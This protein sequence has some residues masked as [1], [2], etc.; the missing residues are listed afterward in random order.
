[1]LRENFDRDFSVW[2]WRCLSSQ[3]HQ[4]V[5]PSTSFFV[6]ADYSFSIDYFKRL[7]HV[8]VVFIP[9]L[10]N[11]DRRIEFIQHLQT[12]VWLALYSSTDIVRSNNDIGFHSGTPR[13]QG[14]ILQL[15][16]FF[17]FT[18]PNSSVGPFV[19]FSLQYCHEHLRHIIHTSLWLPK[20]PTHVRRLFVE[21]SIWTRH[22]ASSTPQFTTCLTILS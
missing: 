4:A 1:M 7:G 12:L 19:I 16:H 21:P 20:T 11:C 3:A 18:V 14:A 6:S 10:K 15:Q 5:S 9:E 13:V 2:G 8:Q 17:I 22:S